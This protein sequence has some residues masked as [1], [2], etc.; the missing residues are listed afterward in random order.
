MKRFL[1]FAVLLVFS[2]TANSLADEPI[3]SSLDVVNMRMQAYNEHDL[4]KFLGTYA[5]DVK[6]YAY[7]DR[8]LGTGKS[9]LRS[10]FEPMFKDGIVSVEIHY[11]A[12][13][14]SY[15][16]NHE[17]VDY[18]DKE[19]EYISIYEVRNGKIISVR[20]VSD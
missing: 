11:Q 9:H 4:N 18:G 20:F 12:A 19:T 7:P 6:I 10:I 14:D 8:H 5:E 15:V 3:A 17:T 1:K 2:I 16:I 13:K